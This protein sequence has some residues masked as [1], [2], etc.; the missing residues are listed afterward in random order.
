VLAD[1]PTASLD[2]R[3]AARIM[4]ILRGANREDGVTVLCN[5]HSLRVARLY[6]DRI[7]GMSG[8]RIVFDG[9]SSGLGDHALRDV[10]GTE[11]VVG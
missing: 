3:N 6:C 9:P 7:V 11:P 4:D 10:Y 2:P 1:E 5:L 8:G